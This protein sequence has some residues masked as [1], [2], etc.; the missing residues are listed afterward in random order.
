MLELSF[1][2]KKLTM[3][4]AITLGTIGVGIAVFVNHVYET[5]TPDD[6]FFSLTVSV[7][8]GLY[9]GLLFLIFI[10]P[11][12]SDVLAKLVY[13]G[14]GTISDF[15]DPM[16]EAR[17]LL[18]KGNYVGAVGELRQVVMSD[19]DNRLAWAEMAKVQL[20][21]LSDPEGSAGTLA[22][23]VESHP[24]KMN[25]AAFLMFRLAEVKLESLE[26]RAGAVLILEQVSELFPDS[27]HSA[28]A[29]HKLRELGAL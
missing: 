10:L 28:N 23:A 5:A 18:A 22:E 3:L 13:Q 25:D 21:H 6:I 19:P 4:R 2:C 27:K 24:W 9:A 15:E 1:T 8:A 20:E 16:R 26:D 11:L 12:V 29:T 7:L 14:G 17:S